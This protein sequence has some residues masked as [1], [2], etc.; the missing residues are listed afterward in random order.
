ML[1]GVGTTL[2]VVIESPSDD[3]DRGWD[4][5]GGVVVAV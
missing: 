1:V 3:T 2:G 4:G 5:A